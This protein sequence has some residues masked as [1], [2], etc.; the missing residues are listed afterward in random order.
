MH[1]IRKWRW[2]E[3]NVEAEEPSKNY[4]KLVLAAHVGH[5]NNAEHSRGREVEEFY[6]ILETEWEPC[7]NNLLKG[8]ID[9]QRS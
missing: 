2:K 6:C 4:A 1:V 7:S 5:G 8:K 9:T 3:V